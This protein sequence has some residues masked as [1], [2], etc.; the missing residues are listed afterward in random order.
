MKY[1]KAVAMLMLIISRK[2]RSGTLQ[3]NEK[4]RKM[5]LIIGCM[6]SIKRI[7][8]AIAK[9]ARY[10]YRPPLGVVPHGVEDSFWDD[11][12]FNAYFR[13]RKHEFLHVMD[14]MR[15]SGK[16]I[17][18]GR[19]N[20][21]QYYP[22]DICMMVLMRRL[23]FPC[24]FADMVL[25]FGI[26]SNRLCDIYHTMIDYIHDRYARKLNR[27]EIWISKFPEFAAVFRRAGLPY[28]NQIMNFD[29]NFKGN[30]PS[31][32]VCEIFT[33]DLTRAKFLLGRNASMA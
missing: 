10:V 7:K 3:P 26:P 33:G 32:R 16:S 24:R 20:K 12:L 21:A 1:R 25:I 13:S 19:K 23:A 6:H 2:R 11:D 5:M 17:L 9:K 29:G 8:A 30:L 27:F 4:R 14:A 31:R 15:L 22:A 18:C 28:P